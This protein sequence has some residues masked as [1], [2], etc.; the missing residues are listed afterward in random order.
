MKIPANIGWPA[1]IIGALVLHVVISLV[2]VWVATSNPSYAVEKD[3]YQKAIHWDD[4]R[5]QDGRNSVLG[6]QIAFDVTRSG[7]AGEPATLDFALT[8]GSGRSLSRATV[9]VETFHNIRAGEILTARMVTDDNGR[10]SAPLPMKRTG[11]WEFR[12]IVDHG[13]DRFTH[14]ETRYLA[15]GPTREE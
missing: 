1:V 5:A 13:T 3:Y 2:T 6:W 14:T 4:K 9:T 10:C 8:D 7:V 12:F 11:V 15:I